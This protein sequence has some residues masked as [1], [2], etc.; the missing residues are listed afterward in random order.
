MYETNEAALYY[1]YMMADGEVSDGEKKVFNLICT[2]LKLNEQQMQ[3]IIN[4]CEKRVKQNQTTCIELLENDANIISYKKLGSNVSLFGFEHTVGMLGA[5]GLNNPRVKRQRAAIVWN[6]INLGYADGYFSTD[7]REIVDFFREEWK[8]PDALY[9][10][11][12]DVA[13]T[14][15]ALEKHKNWVKKLPESDYK[16]EKSKQIRKDMKFT[17]ETIKNTIVELLN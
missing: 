15:L 5:L 12:I 17:Q 7:E 14:C 16:L 1:L 13:E 6:L 10:E 2:E 9:Q 11:M 3:E 8:I 4:E